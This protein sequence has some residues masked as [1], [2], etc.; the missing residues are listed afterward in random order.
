MTVAE[1]S[2]GRWLLEVEGGSA[3]VT[4][5]DDG[6]LIAHHLQCDGREATAALRLMKA[7]VAMGER[8]G[9]AVYIAVDAGQP[10][11]LEVYRKM[12]WSTVYEVM[13]R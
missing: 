12:G 9:K 7:V 5:M 2:P 3:E 13:K 11:L 8:E 6:G 1:V 10:R 4:V